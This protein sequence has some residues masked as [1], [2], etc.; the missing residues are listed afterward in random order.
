M[1]KIVSEKLN[2]IDKDSGSIFP[3]LKSNSPFFSDFGEV[4]ISSINP[5]VIRAWKRHKSLEQYFVVPKGM[6]K[7]VFIVDSKK[8]KNQ[9][10]EIIIGEENYSFIKVPKNV[11][12]GFSNLSSEVSYIVNIIN[13]PHSQ[14]NSE[15]RDY[16]T[17][18]IKGYEW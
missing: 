18:Q 3:I 11:W 14:G 10:K 16:T 5:Q 7:F 12:Y 8:N 6:I 17:N 4:Y 1:V 15:L 2:I 9:F 13:L